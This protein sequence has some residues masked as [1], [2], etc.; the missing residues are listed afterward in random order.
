MHFL[1]YVLIL[2]FFATYSYASSK[3][4]EIYAAKCSSCH[5]LEI[6]EKKQKTRD[7]WKKTIDRMKKYGARFDGKENQIIE[8]L[9]KER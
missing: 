8:Y 2:I 6:I 4:Y 9:T 1:N 3:N 5:G 7:D